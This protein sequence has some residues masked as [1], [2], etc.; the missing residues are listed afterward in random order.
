MK[1]G[2]V[3]GE[4]ETRAD[5]DIGFAVTAVGLLRPQFFAGWGWGAGKGGSKLPLRRC[6]I[7]DKCPCVVAAAPVWLW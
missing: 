7:L 6:C 3:A 4:R 5:L 1:G 2:R